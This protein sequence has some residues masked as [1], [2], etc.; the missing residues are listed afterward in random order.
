[1]TSFS[2]RGFVKS[3]L[4]TASGAALS[5]AMPEI[6]AA[7][8]PAASQPLRFGVNYVPRK[9][10]WYC[11]QDWDA[12]SVAEDL[13]AVRD[14]GMD[15]VRIQCLWPLFQPGINYVSERL[16]ENLN[17]LLE[18]ADLASLD[19]EVTVLNGWMSGIAFMPPWTAPN[20]APKSN[21]FSDPEIIDAEKL[22]FTR[23]AT[24]I[25]SHKRFLGFDLGNE[26]SVLLS[27]G[28]PVTT[29]QADGWTT[30]MFRHVN[31]VA[32]GKFHVNG[33]D[34]TPWWSDIAFTRQNCANQGAAS[35][36]H[37]YGYFSG[38]LQRY[39]YSGVGTLHLAEYNVELAYA[40]QT[41]LSRRV[42][43]E[44]IGASPEWM[45]ESY[46]ADYA[47][48]VLESAADTGML[49]GFTWWCSHDID[50]SI[51][52]FVSMEYT[53]GLIDQKN[54][55]K[56][57][58]RI[59][60]ALAGELRGKI[61][62]STQRRTAMVIPEMGLS[63]HHHPPDWTYGAAFMNLIQR[64]KKPCIVLESRVA[65][66]DYLRAR[67]ITELIPLAEAINI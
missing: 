4:M 63:P 15:H 2:R 65:D 29:Q 53:L 35:I 7:K 50:K 43:V 31:N 39:G 67:G 66:E 9:N 20:A 10:W 38:A 30:E 51:E 32:P 17:S 47:R 42:W 12:Q 1:M 21:I 48:Q 6:L 8:P 46:M 60:S 58:G 49:W 18:A 54:R 27:R 33:L 36:V 64:G 34:H 26:L 55:I 44:E 13:L 24:A 22:L 57:L 37:S 45:P 62:S 25:G 61:L 14:L 16:L 56:P 41:N 3:S 40:Y 5:S 11:W 23:I 52:G 28:N 19:V 59:V